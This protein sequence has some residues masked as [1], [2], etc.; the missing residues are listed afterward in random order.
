MLK[1]I[2]GSLAA[3]A[4]VLLAATSAPAA[5]LGATLQSRLAGLADS[6]DAGVVIVAFHTENG[7][8]PQHLAVLEGLGVLR[9]TTLTQLGMVA[10][11]ATAGQVRAL[12]ANPAVRS[13]WANDRLFYHMEQARILTGVDRLGVDA[14][15]T[16]A[17]GGLPVSGAGNFSIVVNDSGI[18]ATHA[19]L[20]F[21]SKVIEN[22][23]ILTDSVTAP[24]FTPLLAVPGV[25]NTDTH[26]GHGT[27]VAGI[28]GGTGQ[29]SGGRYAGV[30]PGA[31]LIGC[32]SG[33]GLFVLNA[34]GG[35]EW[36]LANQYRFNIRVVSNSWGGSGAFDPNDPVNIATKKLYDRNIVVVFSAGNSGPGP[37]THNPSSKAP[38]VIS[39][40]AGTKEGGL[41][42][43]SSRGI[44]RAERLTNADPNDDYDAPTITAPGT[45]REFASNAAKFTAAIVSTRSTSNIVANGTTDDLEIAPTLLPF[46]TQISGTSM[47]CPF[48]SGVIALML[49]ADPTLTVDQIK[50]ILTE[51]ATPMPGYEDYE[52]G[53][54]YV[55]AYAAVDKVFNR[56][57]A[58]GALVRPAFNAQL[59]TTPAA[60]EE[61]S[62]DYVPQAPG[63][64]STNTYRFQVEPGLGSIDVRID[65]G[66]NAVTDEVGNS[67]GLQ[68]YAPDGRV[69]SSGLTLP[70]LDSPRREI[71]VDFPVAGEWVAEIR[72]L[73]GLA[74]VPEVSSPFGI[75]VPETVNG[76]VKR[77]AITLQHVPD[78][79]G[80]PAEA[81]IRMALLTRQMDL[82]ATGT[83]RPDSSVTRADFARHLS[84]NTP[85]RQN[86]PATRRFTDVFGDLL[87]IAHAV[88]AQGSTLRDYDFTPAGMMS[89]SG[90]LFAPSGLVKRVDM[91]VALV[92]ALGLDA[93][94]QAM[95]GRTVT[96]VY[97]GQTLAL[98]D[99]A[100]IPL[101]LR[102]YVQIALDKGLLQAFYTLEQGPLDF[103]PTIK[104]RVR[105]N[106]ATTRAFLAIALANFSERFNGR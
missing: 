36:S 6:A 46:Y 41:A 80:H 26:V 64:E 95:A 104:A 42:S 56:T 67:M 2:A 102:G 12:A 1:R 72:G 9:G 13:V 77:F 54:G 84:Y 25:P 50:A 40:A 61:F 21:G 33:A 100:D 55:N 75:A 91:A 96:V 28:I 32:G 76:I 66:T 89:A 20:Q 23:Q 49:D 97:S 87:S 11:P 58:Y 39:V 34:L 83:F 18:D 17:N 74:A 8:Q 98:T 35:L 4:F 44:P 47:S 63:P 78:I 52:V 45:G 69:Y 105:P 65:F 62:I 38:W 27:H 48:I 106:N 53:V 73:R 103:E 29:A 93:E 81:Q 19:D 101:A 99:N 70:A 51:T 94:A 22:V 15:I 85:L 5:T 90:S 71:I 10:I 88:T 37:D 57:R 59:T 7:L 16:R 43:F 14:A 3:V 86:V 82:L 79:V 30:A 92:R 24:G 68:L 31:K 60:F